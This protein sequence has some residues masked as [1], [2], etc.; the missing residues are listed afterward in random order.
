MKAD[1]HGGNKA[2]CLC[3]NEGVWFSPT[4]HTPPSFL[5]LSSI[6]PLSSPCTGR[7]RES[8]AA[9]LDV[10]HLPALRD[11]RWANNVRWRNGIRRDG[12]KTKTVVQGSSPCPH[13]I[14]R[15][16]VHEPGSGQIERL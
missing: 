3:D 5:H 8:S 7:R 10:G 16:S 1:T 15:N 11:R 12:L 2:F 9:A 14:C 4:L 13:N 6:F